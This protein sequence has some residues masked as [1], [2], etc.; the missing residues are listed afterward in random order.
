MTEQITDATLVSRLQAGDDDAFAELLALHGGRVLATARRLLRH[1][2][3]AQDAVQ[4]AFLS[5]FRAIGSFD[6]RAALGT[7]L[8]RIVVN[9]CLQRIR[10]RDRHPEEPLDHLTPAFDSTGHH[11]RR[12]PIWTES[13]D[14]L[15]QRADVRRLVRETIDELPEGAR[16]ALVLRD[17]EGLSTAEVAAALQ[18]EPGTARVRVHRARQ[19]LKTLLER[20]D[21]DGVLE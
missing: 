6:G 14:A 20:K 3:D 16:T 8:H 2:A 17:V 19:A 21:L 1:D 18:V 9:A 12:P 4:E 5:A 10:K 7:W 11:E 15:V 13:P